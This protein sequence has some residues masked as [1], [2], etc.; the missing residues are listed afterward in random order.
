MNGPTSS[1]V[2]ERDITK[3]YFKFYS[4]SISIKFV[5]RGLFAFK[6]RKRFEALKQAIIDSGYTSYDLS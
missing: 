3:W 6:K 4:S 5:F 1:C 2:A